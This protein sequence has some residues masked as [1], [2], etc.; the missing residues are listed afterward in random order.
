MSNNRKTRFSENNDNEI[1]VYLGHDFW[2]GCHRL[3]ANM[4]ITVWSIIISAGLMPFP[5]IGG[6]YVI[7]LWNAYL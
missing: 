5:D 1:N 3:G 2:A 7:V 6:L 4:G